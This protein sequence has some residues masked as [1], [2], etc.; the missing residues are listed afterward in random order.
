MLV[1][2]VPTV[3]CSPGVPVLVRLK[4]ADVMTPATVAL[5]V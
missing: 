3:S 1:A 5:T 4:L 2:E